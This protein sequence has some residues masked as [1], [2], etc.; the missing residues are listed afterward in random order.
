MSVSFR[1]RDTTSGSLGSTK[2]T[3]K[4]SRIFKGFKVVSN[5]MSWRFDTFSN[6]S[7]FGGRQSINTLFAAAT[8]ADIFNV[9][10]IVRANPVPGYTL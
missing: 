9:F 7:Q 4:P 5:P 3:H 8:N 10:S 6:I 1:K 2:Y